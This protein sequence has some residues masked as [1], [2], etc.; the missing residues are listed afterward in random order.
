M[1]YDVVGRLFQGVCKKGAVHH[2]LFLLGPPVQTGILQYCFKLQC[3]NRSQLPKDSIMKVT[4]SGTF[5]PQLRTK[6]LLVLKW[7]PVTKYY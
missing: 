7:L 2:G 3:D 1:L 5:L 4:D 6:T